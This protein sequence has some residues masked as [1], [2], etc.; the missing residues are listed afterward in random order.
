MQHTQVVE[1][2]VPSAGLYEKWLEVRCLF[3]GLRIAWVSALS[4]LVGFALFL[5]A[6]PAQDILLETKGDLAADAAYWATFYGLVILAWA[7]PVFVSARW[8]LTFTE[9]RPTAPAVFESL[10]R[11]VRQYV[12]VLLVLLCFFAILVGQFIAL[13]DAPEIVDETSQ[14]LVAEAKNHVE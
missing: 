9:A 4:A 11:W 1:P 3:V 12:P 10:P 2:C 5:S 13:R 8:I 7:L 6:P 14:A